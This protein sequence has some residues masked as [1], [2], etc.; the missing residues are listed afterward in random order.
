M[1][2]RE[3]AIQ[4]AAKKQMVDMESR[5]EGLGKKLETAAQELSQVKHQASENEGKLK[6]QI[7]KVNR[8]HV[9]A[10]PCAFTSC[11]QAVLRHRVG[12]ALGTEPPKHSYALEESSRW[13]N[14]L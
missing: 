8:L 1:A 4:N 11:L 13:R 2:E 9:S 14:L 6:K 10:T 12:A 3:T 5:F 7:T